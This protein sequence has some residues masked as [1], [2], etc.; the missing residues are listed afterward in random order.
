MRASFPFLLV[1]FTGLFSF[2]GLAQTFTGGGGTI[3][4]NNTTASFNLNVNGLGSNLNTNSFGLEQVCLSINHTW[5]EDLEVSLRSPDGTTVILF[6]GLGGDG[7]NFT[8]TCFRQDAGT[9]IVSVAAPFSGTFR[10]QNNLSAHNNGQNGNGQWR[11][12]IRDMN[13]QDQGN[14]VSWSLTFGNQPAQPFQFESSNLP[15]LVINTNNITIPDEPKLAANLNIIYNGPGERNY[16]TDTTY[17]YSGQ[18]GIERRGSTSQGMPKKP[19]G[20]ETWDGQQN[21]I[22]ASLLGMPEESD[23]ILTANYSD[24]T[25]MRNALS[26]ELAN[27]TGHYAPRTRFCEV[28]LNGQYDGVYLLCEKIK[29]DS[30]RVAIAKLQTQDIAGEELTG[31]YIIKIDKM[32]GS[33]GAG[34]PSAVFPPN[35]SAGQTIFFQYVYPKPDSIRPEQAAYIESFVDS[36]ETVLNNAGFQDPVTGWR[37]YMDENTVIDFFLINEMSRNVDGYR[38]STFLHKEKSTQGGKLKM[39][40]VWD[41]DIAWQ[42]ADYCSGQSVTGWAYNFNNVCNTDGSLVPFWWQR[43][44]QDTLFNKRL[45]CRWSELRQSFLHTDSLRTRIDTIAAYLNESQERNF[46]EWPIL[47]TYVWPNPGPIPTTY[48]GEIA[49]LKQW[50]SDRLGWMDSQINA[51]QTQAPTVELGADTAICVGEAVFLDAG[52][53]YSVLWSTGQTDTA[54]YAG[55]A[56]TYSVEV[57]SLYGCHSGDSVTVSV[58]PLPDAEFDVNAQSNFTFAFTPD[59]SGGGDY[60]WNFG[61]GNT[62]TD[63][64]ATH[65]YSQAGAY[66]VSLTVTDANGCLAATTQGVQTQTLSVQEAQGMGLS[67]YPNP[68]KEEIHVRTN[69]SSPVLLR[70]VSVNGEVLY[71]SE[72]GGTNID[73]ALPNMPAGMYYLWIKTQEGQTFTRKLIK[74]E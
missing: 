8:G 36:F 9:S 6:S 73:M 3:P 48:A 28:V 11:L 49:K 20:F 45:Y 53:P 32:T 5:D 19:Y 59:V 62:S 17:D 39:G 47:G 71:E 46:T 26:Y 21:D 67:V 60:L 22:K 55:T 38:I 37:K 66:T 54:I 42:N 65:T 10:P 69:G 23:W 30:G 43:F 64:M 72:Y 2:P 31:G 56:G 12:R 29:R 41:Y 13:Q 24:K 50:V 52:N 15:I 14:L 25:L 44:R 35:A 18:I 27:K 33:G 4:D 70:L 7:D 68:F 34:F 51:Y 1:S 63:E 61:D 58:N 40:P 16:L 57:E 74:T